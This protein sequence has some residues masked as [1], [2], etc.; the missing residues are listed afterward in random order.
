MWRLPL[1]R[2]EATPRANLT[3]SFLTARAFL[4]EVERSGQPR[5]RR[6]AESAILHGLLLSLRNEI[7]RVR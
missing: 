3:A 7:V 5:P 6:P 4:R 2:W 1:E